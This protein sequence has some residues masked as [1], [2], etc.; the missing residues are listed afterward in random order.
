[1]NVGVK[2]PSKPYI[3]FYINIIQTYCFHNLLDSW[4]DR[5]TYY[6]SIKTIPYLNTTNNITNFNWLNKG[7]RP[8][9]REI[10]L[11][12]VIHSGDNNSIFRRYVHV[13]CH[14]RNPFKITIW[15]SLFHNLIHFI[16]NQVEMKCIITSTSST[17]SRVIE[18]WL[19]TCWTRSLVSSYHFINLPNNHNFCFSLSS[20]SHSTVFSISISLCTIT[21]ISRKST[22]FINNEII[23]HSLF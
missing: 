5:T 2:R 22:W 8:S 9:W 12:M 10:T 11:Y 19:L 16:Q 13:M 18:G 23:I 15:F 14:D 17:L 21:I 7:D 4:I 1:M 20:N 6:T 3:S